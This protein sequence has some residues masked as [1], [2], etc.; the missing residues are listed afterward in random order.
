MDHFTNKFSVS[1][2]HFSETLFIS[3][4]KTDV[5]LSVNRISVNLRGSDLKVER[6]H[7]EDVFMTQHYHKAGQETTR[8]NK[9]H[10]PSENGR[11]E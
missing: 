3:L 11:E 6:Y 5:P 2:V 4:H 7:Q 1:D 9:M 8:C 10:F